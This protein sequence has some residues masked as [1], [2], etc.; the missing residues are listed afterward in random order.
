MNLIFQ[1]PKVTFKLKLSKIL[2]F[3]IPFSLYELFI[4]GGGRFFEIG[5]LTLRMYVFFLLLGVCLFVIVQKGKIDKV[6]FAISMVFL[7]TLIIATSIGIINGAEISY[8]FEDVKPLFYFFSIIYLS[9]FININ[10]I[11][12]I[13]QIIKTS[14]LFLTLA[15]YLLIFLLFFNY[16]HFAYL[17]TISWKS[18]EIMFRGSDGLFF[19]KGFL[20]LNIAFFFYF[21]KPGKFSFFLSAFIGLAILLTLTRG[22]IFAL[23][24]CL[25]I[26]YIFINRNIIKKIV[27]FFTSIILV[28]FYFFYMITLIGEKSSSNNQRI[29]QI[30]QVYES[31][32]IGSFLWGH[33][34]GIGVPIRPIHMEI[35]YLEIFH[36]QGLIGLL[37]WLGLFFLILY[38]YFKIK[39]FYYDYI[40][41]SFLLGTLFVYIQTF[42]NPFL[43]NPIGMTFIIL[44][45]L[46][47]RTIYLNSSNDLRLHP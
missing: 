33:G 18:G 43:N 27:L 26:Y 39:R 42:T 30:N 12:S 22:F 16:I 23:G 4:G 19:Y 47:F 28:F 21:L 8:L 29:L 9:Q 24:I 3:I 10:T 40:I 6:V 20:Y 25:T 44:T 41:N 38:Y 7:F 15:Y 2:F 45:L 34:F 14:G 46:V 37:F 17:Y 36:K 1:I 5:S 32:N 35:S 13:T 31:T 11:S